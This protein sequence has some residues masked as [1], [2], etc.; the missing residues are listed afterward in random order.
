MNPAKHKSV[1]TKILKDI[2]SDKTLG[3]ALGFKGG[4]AAS[5]FYDLPR[6][7]VDLDFDLLDTTKEEVML[8]RIKTMLSA[9]GRVEEAVKKRFTLFF[10]LS[11]QKNERHLKV[12][13]SRRPI[14][15]IYTVLSWLG[16]PMLVMSRQ[17][18]FAHKLAALLDRKVFANRDLFDVWFF[19]KSDWPLNEEKLKELTGE[20]KAAYLKKCIDYIEKLDERYILQGLGELLDE[21]QKIWARQHLRSEAAFQLKLELEAISQI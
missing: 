2:Y 11:Y 17:D 6:F 20:N 19:A 14:K 16:I 7:S 5:L 8:K 13:I 3:P 9:Y 10:L 18:M 15:N 12:E 21:K 1:M 4:T